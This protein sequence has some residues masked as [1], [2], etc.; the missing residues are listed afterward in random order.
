M[1]PSSGLDGMNTTPDKIPIYSGSQN[2]ALITESDA[3]SSGSGEGGML[4]APPKYSKDLI[5]RGDGVS[6]IKRVDE[7]EAEELQCDV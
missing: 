7:E 4:S 5:L 1:F 2:V 3:M 6:T